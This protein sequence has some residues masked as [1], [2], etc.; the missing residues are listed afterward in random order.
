M[1]STN[2]LSK[3]DAVAETAEEFPARLE[4]AT[5]G[6]L[7]LNV[8]VLEHMERQVGLTPLRALQSLDRNG[9]S[10]V[11]ELADDLGLV[12]STASRLSDRLADAGWI[13]RRAA[14]ANRRST[15]LELTDSGRAVLEELVAYRVRS[16]SA[17]VDR[18]AT[19]TAPR[20]CG[21]PSHSLA[22][23]TKCPIRTANNAANPANPAN[24]AASATTLTGTAAARVSTVITMVSA[25]D[26]HA[27]S[28]ACAGTWRS[29]GG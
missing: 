16:M 17:V 13:T 2:N 12:P 9:P 18:M 29:E 10:L 4:R 7:E 26:S 15:L 25:Q 3:P 24:P 8:E 6:L 21:A 5:R 27:G 19:K 1:A 11:G 20:L 23:S 22:P 28:G 14:P